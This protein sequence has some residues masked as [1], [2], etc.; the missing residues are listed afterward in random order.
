MSDA[1]DEYEGLVLSEDDLRMLDAPLVRPLSRGA[2]I[3]GSA[4]YATD[5]RQRLGT[6]TESITGFKPHSWQ[7]DCA[8]AS[9]LGQDVCLIAGTGF[10]KTLPFIMNCWLDPKL[11]VWIISPLNALGNQQARTFKDWGLEAIAVNA[12]T[13]YPGLR[14]VSS[15]RVSLILYI[16]RPV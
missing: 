8:V 5:Y 1:F 7:L 15:S 12:T 6:R 9:H 10:G 11:I 13:N 14:K 16:L 3:I 4:A 2:L